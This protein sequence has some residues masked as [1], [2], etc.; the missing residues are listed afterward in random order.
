MMVM[1]ARINYAVSQNGDT[2]DAA[3]GDNNVKADGSDDYN[4][5]YVDGDV[6]HDDAGTDDAA[7]DDADSDAD[8]SADDSDATGCDA[9]Y[10]ESVMTM[11]MMV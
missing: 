5:A 9:D 2:D 8:D 11:M 6:V 10:A 4:D 7:Y 3:G 1:M